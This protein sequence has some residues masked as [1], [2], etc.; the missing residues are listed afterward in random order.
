MAAVSFAALACL[1]EALD[2]QHSQGVTLHDLLQVPMC[3]MW[4]AVLF[5]KMLWHPH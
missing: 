4:I 5:E 1:P 3:Q 2:G